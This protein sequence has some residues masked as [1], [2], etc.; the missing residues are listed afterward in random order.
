M[1]ENKPDMEPSSLDVAAALVYKRGT[2]LFALI[3]GITFRQLSKAGRLKEVGSTPHLWRS[4]CK[5]KYATPQTAL[6]G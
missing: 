1:Q 5:R 6:Y 2:R 4:Y 3:K